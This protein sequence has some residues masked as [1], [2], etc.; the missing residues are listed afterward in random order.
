MPDPDGGNGKYTV[1]KTEIP[2]LTETQYLIEKTENKKQA[3]S[4]K[5]L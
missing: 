1:N 4:G 2:A 5:E 3:Y